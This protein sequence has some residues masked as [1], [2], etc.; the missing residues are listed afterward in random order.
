MISNF[1]SVVDLALLAA[2]DIERLK[3]DVAKKAGVGLRVINNALKDRKKRN[4]EERRRA[5]AESQ[6]TDIRV[7]LA[8][9]A[10]D[11]ELLATLQPIDGIL[12]QVDVPEPPFRNIDG[13]YSRLIERSH[14]GLHLLRGI[15]LRR[16]QNITYP[17]PQNRSSAN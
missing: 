10:D 3:V 5:Q 1:V 4:A 15:D 8:A 16:I 14:Q 6:P 11:A 12:S 13:R 7:R 17:L 9:P 2:E